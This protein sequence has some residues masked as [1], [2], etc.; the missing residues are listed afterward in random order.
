MRGTALDA[1][2]LA[3]DAMV[4]MRRI[5]IATIEG[6]KEEGRPEAAFLRSMRSR[7]QKRNSPPTAI[8]STSTSTPPSKSAWRR[9]QLRLMPQRSL[10][11]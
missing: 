7:D 8:V 4:D 3:F 2:K 1:A 11:S 6:A 5:D 10:K 9:S